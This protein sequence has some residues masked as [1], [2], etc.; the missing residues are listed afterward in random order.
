VEIRV[1][2]VGAFYLPGKIRQQKWTRAKASRHEQTW[3]QNEG[4]W[5]WRLASDGS[6]S[7]RSESYAEVR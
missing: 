2:T 4:Q 3:E 5:G 1:K 6:L 7:A